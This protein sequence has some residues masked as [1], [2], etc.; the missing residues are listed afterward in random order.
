[1]TPRQVIESPFAE[2]AKARLQHLTETMVFLEYQET[3]RP[4]AGAGHGFC[5]ERGCFC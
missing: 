2:N 4:P 1:M 5:R 3:R